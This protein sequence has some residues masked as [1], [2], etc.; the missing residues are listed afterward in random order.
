MIEVANMQICKYASIRNDLGITEAM[1]RFLNWGQ[2]TYLR[3]CF[4]KLQR[5]H[6]DAQTLSIGS[7][8]CARHW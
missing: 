7:S 2:A 8:Q 6:R 3:E 4:R 1:P 5:K